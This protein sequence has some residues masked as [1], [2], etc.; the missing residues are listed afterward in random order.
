MKDKHGGRPLRACLIT[1]L[2]GRARPPPPAPG[3]ARRRRRRAGASRWPR[4]LPA[5]APT[6]APNRADYY[7]LLRF[8]RARNYEFDK[9]T[10]MWQDHMEWRKA[11]D[12]DTI[13]EDFHFQEKELF[14]TAYPQVRGAAGAA[15][16][17]AAA[18]AGRG[19]RAPA[20]AAAAGPSLGSRAGA[21]A[22]GGWC[23]GSGPPAAGRQ[24]QGMAPGGRP[25]APPSPGGSGPPAQQQ[26]APLPRRARP[27][28]IRPPPACLLQG[29]HKTDK[30]GRPVYI[31][32]LGKIDIVTI[33]QITTEDRMI[34][35]HIQEWERCIKQILP[36]C[37]KLQGRNIDQTFGI[38][39]V[40]GALR[41]RP[42]PRPRPPVQL[43]ARP[44]PGSSERRS[45]AQGGAPPARC[46]P[47]PLPT[48]PACLCRRAGVGMAHLTG[49]VKRLVSAFTKYD[50]DNYPEMLG[51]ICIINA[52]MMFK[53]IWA[54]IKP[55]LNARTQGKI[56]VGRSAAQ[57]A[58]ASPSAGPARCTRCTRC[59]RL[60]SPCLT[61]ATWPALPLP[62]AQICGRD[63]VRDLKVWID[64]E[65]LLEYLGG[66]SKGT[67]LDD[68]GPW[69][70][71]AVLTKLGLPVPGESPPIKAS[72]SRLGSE[73]DDGYA[74]PRCATRPGPGPAACL[75][76]LPCCLPGPAAWLIAACQ[77]RQPTGPAERWRLAACTICQPAPR[78][79]APPTPHPSPAPCAQVRG[80]VPVGGLGQQP[81]GAQRLAGAHLHQP[82]PGRR[83]RHRAA[84][85]AGRLQPDAQVRRGAAGPC[86]L[87]PGR[88]LPPARPPLRAWPGA[89][90]ASWGGAG[91]PGAARRRAA[92]GPHITCVQA[93]AFARLTPHTHP[94]LPP[95]PHPQGQG[96]AGARAAAGAAAA[97]AGA[98]AQGLRAAE[99]LVAQL[100]QQPGARRHA[101]APAGGAGDWHG[102]AAAR[103]GAG[104]AREQQAE[105][106]Q[107]ARVLLRHVRPRPAAAAAA[108]ARGRPRARRCSHRRA[109]AR[110]WGRVGNA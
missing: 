93:A 86:G 8:L 46:P 103:A 3:R 10:K 89:A 12:V 48:P 69:S 105:Q 23:A 14:V 27:A 63:Y 72:L 104:L 101:A 19:D 58:S 96:A 64:D 20:A 80:V 83:G 54:I 68:V 2:R 102:R 59:N 51:H 32:H 91:Q 44:P 13:I 28:P 77:P 25:A 33:K 53:A 26:Q 79:A 1:A 22:C 57:P 41:A 30:M 43:A 55:M 34:K 78:Q 95:P 65:N 50:Q 70:D 17:A 82:P 100:A 73:V 92:A 90:A 56:E 75:C 61:S 31:Q 11:F 36:V 21:R 110:F 18:A 87:L 47:L 60:T 98:A 9:A 42:R 67:L 71:P 66:S 108:A 52:P 6:R 29:Y 39:D 74:T 45:A 24:Q 88:L 107:G 37:S 38:M 109:A 94:H 35:F 16:A 40:K 106:A 97:A 81:A 7:T 76:C 5:R 15:A 62:L 85:G 49:E 84:P 99:R 4:P